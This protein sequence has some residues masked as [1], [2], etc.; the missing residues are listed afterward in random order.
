MSVNGIIW[1]KAMV[2]FLLLALIAGAIFKVEDDRIAGAIIYLSIACFLLIII[3]A[4]A[5]VFS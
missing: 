3:A 2:A 1:L 5:F 4:I